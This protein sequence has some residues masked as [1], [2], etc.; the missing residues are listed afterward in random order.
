MND[1]TKSMIGA[2]LR[3]L[4]VGMPS[5]PAGPNPFSMVAQAWSEYEGHKFKQR[6]EEFVIAIHARLTSLESL[7]VACLERVLNL[8]E[9]AALLEEAVAAASREP[10]IEKRQA[11]ADFYVAA[12]N[13][14]LGNDLDSI[15]S[16]LQALEALTPTDLALLSKFLPHGMCTGDGLSDS[17][18]SPW[19]AVGGDPRADEEWDRRLTSVLMSVTKLETRGLI[20]ETRRTS[21]FQH[22]GDNG[23]WYNV[24][25][26]KAW[27][28]S[29]PG[30]QLLS[31]LSAGH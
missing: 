16:L 24:F 28:I 8:E 10:K 11:F 27:R 26:R 30:R 23:A 21:A 6:V 20:I 7:Q 9:Q 17:W 29:Q 12:I 3:T 22:S 2:S 25:R 14:K 13:G 18:M 1:D 31:A 19:E 5:L 4:L 15:R